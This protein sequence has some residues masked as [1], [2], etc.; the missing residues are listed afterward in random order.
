MNYCN[1]ITFNK[2]MAIHTLFIC[3][4]KSNFLPTFG[5]QYTKDRYIPTS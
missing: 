1:I 5:K 3:V 2:I 4:V